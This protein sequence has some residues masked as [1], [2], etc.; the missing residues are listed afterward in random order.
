MTKLRT[1]FQQD[2]F[3]IVRDFYTVAEMAEFDTAL[4]RYVAEVVPHLP[5]DYVFHEAGGGIKSMNRLDEHDTFFADFKRHPRVLQLV[6]ELLGTSATQI[7]AESLQFFGKPAYEGSVTPWHQD[8]GFQHY[9]P[10]ESLMLWLALDDVDE[11][12]GCVVFARGSHT[13]GTV[14]HVPSGVLG[15]SQTVKEPPDPLL[16]P[17]VNAAMRRGS[18]SLHHCDMFHRSG[19][20]RSARSRRALAVNL[21]TTRAVAD[22]EKRARVKAEAARLLQAEQDA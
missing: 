10:P 7:I 5:P 9:A 12:N 21:R 13:L 3:A 17:E 14:A 1:T 6:A 4:A 22:V 2:G 18:I 19:A 20:N 8:N 15:F 11:E 16:F